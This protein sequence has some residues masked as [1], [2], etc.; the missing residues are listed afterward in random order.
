MEKRPLACQCFL[1]N[2]ICDLSEVGIL[3]HVIS[4]ISITLETVQTLALFLPLHWALVEG[5]WR[6]I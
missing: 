2:N 6:R 4:V 5:C 1:N 3:Y